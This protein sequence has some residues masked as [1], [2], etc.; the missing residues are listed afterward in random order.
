[1]AKMF[2]N[3]DEAAK[4]L[5][6]TEGEVREMASK[7][8]LTE[9]RDGDKLIF[10]VD[11]VNLLAGDGPEESGMIPLTDSASGDTAL[12]LDA[13][14]T[15]LGFDSDGSG[16]AD[17]LSMNDSGAKSGVS[18]FDADEVGE[19]DASADTLIT[20]DGGIGDV[21]LESFGSGSGL[22]DLTRDSDDTGMA[23]EG[24][25]D[26]L[27]SGDEGGATGTAAAGADLFDGPASSGGDLRFGATPTG[28]GAVAVAEP[29]DGK[30]SGL[31]GGLAIGAIVSLLAGVAIVL[32]GMVGA[33]PADLASM[34]NNNLLI[35]VGAL[36]IITLIAGG[37]GFFIGGKS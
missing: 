10:K 30:G 22:M 37:I 29:Y 33:P 14:D 3:L 34:V 17:M 32:M 36:L 35:P 25:L 19:I 13:S 2:Y 21:S 7:G 11:Q 8:Q 12:G 20:G 5:G 27:Y 1:M 6:K 18:V 16:S 4:K 28:P 26:E 9:F 31:A 24:L 15:G 23:T